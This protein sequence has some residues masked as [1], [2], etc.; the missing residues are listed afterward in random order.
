[1]EAYD[2]G[3]VITLAVSVNAALMLRQGR[4]RAGMS[5]R[6]LAAASGVSQEEIARIESG[7]VDPRTRTLGRLLAACGYELSAAERPTASSVDRAAIRRLL[8]LPRAERTRVYLAENRNAL[9]FLASARRVPPS[10]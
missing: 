6:R 7:R 4:A 10:A 3:Y 8:A 5:Q 1:V 2:D 9:A